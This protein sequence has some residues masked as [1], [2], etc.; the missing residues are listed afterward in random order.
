MKLNA[1][2]K[3]IEKA[4]PKEWALPG[5]PVGL[6]I[7]DRDKDIKR[8]AV[9]L[10]VSSNL[11]K[12]AKQKKA[13]LILA[14]HPLIF[15][16]V[17]TLLENNPVQRLVRQLIRD[18]IALYAAHTNFDLHPQGM[19][20]WWAEKLG[21]K[22]CHP[23][24]SKPQADQLKLVTFIPPD[25]TDRLRSALSE[26][27]AGIIG[28]YDQCSYTLHGFGTFR[29]SEHSNPFAG[30]AGQFE[31]ED[32]QRIEMV[33]PASK[34]Q[35]VVNALFQHHPYEEP[36]YDLY[37]LEDFRDLSQALWI[38]E[39]DKKISWNAFQERVIKSLPRKPE[40]GGV[41]PD[42]KR[43]IKTIALSTG[44]GNNFLP[45]VKNLG[46]D[47]Y[48]TG[49]MG[50]HLLWEANEDELNVITVGHGVSEFCFPKAAIP[51]LSKY[52]DDVEWMEMG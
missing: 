24:A 28:E 20:K 46:V 15:K 1:L 35:S 43:K 39:L 30:Q 19:G 51:L 48:L 8:V 37:P 13:E 33:L 10:E 45:I 29:G 4:I 38:G 41:R 34:K 47:V 42:T 21:C 27:G 31:T 22:S 18:D 49:E 11:V 5:D 9:S 14:H 6:Q 16:P 25:Y 36:A 12:Q 7:G 23:L 50:Y 32:E 2:V 3:I 52:G 44:S 17:S 26:A 40:L